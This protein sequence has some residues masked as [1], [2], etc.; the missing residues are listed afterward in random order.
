MRSRYPCPRFPSVISPDPSTFFTT[1]GMQ[2]HR[3]L[4][5]DPGVV[6]T[7]TDIQHCLRLND[8]D[9]V[10]D[11]THYLDFHMLGLFSFRE[12]T[13]QQGV[14]FWIG[15]LQTLGLCP[16]TVTI[17]PDR[18]QW[19]SLYDR[20]P[21]R[22][23]EDP[24]CTWSD[25][26]SDGQIEGY[27]TEFYLDGVEIGNIVNPR[28]DCLDCGF[29]GERLQRLLDQRTG[30]PSS[31]PTRQ[32]V[33][34]RTIGVLL[35]SGVRPSN[36]KQG[37]VLRSLIREQLHLGHPLPEHP[38]IDQERTRRQK[39]VDSLPR[40]RHQYPDKPLSYFWETHGIHPEDWGR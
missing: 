10:G 22:I 5:V 3:S 28:G 31:P 8:L 25:G 23:Q 36:T 35:E 16:D 26:Q 32:E 13:V 38:L 2:K 33:L 37:Y 7:R 9:E 24:E 14:D 40:L 29:G 21:V 4:F 20:Y 6:G 39:V 15:F 11:G 1:S 30:T 17:H 34:D 19:R 12:L 18:P 27:C